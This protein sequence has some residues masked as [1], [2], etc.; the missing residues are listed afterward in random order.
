MSEIEIQKLLDYIQS[1]F[2]EPMSNHFTY[3]LVE[4]TIRYAV[5]NLPSDMVLYHIAEMIPEIS[6]D[7][8]ADVIEEG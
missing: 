8:L 7:E 2:P 6:A 1:E 4:N 5:D 3:D